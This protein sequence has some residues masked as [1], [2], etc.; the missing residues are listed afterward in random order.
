MSSLNKYRVHEV[1]KDF[2]LGSKEIADIL[3]GYAQTPKNHMQVLTDQELAILFEYLTQH[4]Q[5][6]SIEEIYADTY[7]EPVPPPP[8]APTPVIESRPAVQ[9]GGRLPISAPAS[10]PAPAPGRPLQ[11]ERPPQRFQD[12]RQPMGTTP[13]VPRPDPNGP[14]TKIVDTRKAATVNLD[15]YDERL[16]TLVPEKAQNMAQN[17]AQQKEKFKK[18]TDQRRPTPGFGSKRRQ[19]EQDKLRRL[20]LEIAKKQPM[21]VE[22][23]DEISVG[24]LASRLKKTGAEVV[25]QLIKMG[26]MASVSDIIDYDTAALAAMELGAKVSREV[27]VTIEE[28]LIDVRADNEEDLVSRSPVV[29]VMGHVDH[30]KTSLLD[31]IRKSDVVSGEAGGYYPAYRSLPCA[32]KRKAYHLFGHTGP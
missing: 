8:P 14:K 23:P 17:M 29:V 13:I 24:E 4:Q 25:R 30:G 9:P 1:A 27:V 11:T 21:K 3:T 10:A 2:N 18:T 16:E 19:E 28:R 20:Q 31:V 12:Q 26:V 7:R 22:I 6:G 32:D 15:R 5:I